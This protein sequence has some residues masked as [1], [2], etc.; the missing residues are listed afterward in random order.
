MEAFVLMRVGGQWRWW[1]GGPGFRGGGG[2]ISPSSMMAGGS[3]ARGLGVGEVLSDPGRNGVDFPP[4]GA[5]TG[6]DELFLLS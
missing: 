1:E 3:G 5:S 4:N 2:P 6:R